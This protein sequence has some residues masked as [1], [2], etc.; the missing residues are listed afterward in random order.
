VNAQDYHDRILLLALFDAREQLDNNFPFLAHDPEPTILRAA[1]ERIRDRMIRETRDSAETLAN[2]LAVEAELASTGRDAAKV[3][4]EVDLERAIANVSARIAREEGRESDAEV[5]EASERLVT[6]PS[7]ELARPRPRISGTRPGRRHGLTRWLAA[8]AGGRDDVLAAVP[9]AQFRI[10]A[11]GSILFS[12]AILAGVSAVIAIRMCASISLWSAIVIGTMWSA[13]IYIIERSIILTIDRRASRLRAIVSAIPRI[14]LIAIVAI[15]IATPL[16]LAVFNREIATQV[17][18]D[19]QSTQRSYQAELT[20]QL[21]SLRNQ[22]RT[23][24]LAAAGLAPGAVSGDPSVRAATAEA[25][26][27]QLQYDKATDTYLRLSAQA[28][29]EFD[30][31]CGTH[32]PGDGAQYRDLKNQADVSRAA[33]AQA[34]AAL[35]NARAQLSIVTSRASAVHASLAKQDL[36][37][38]QGALA[39]AERQLASTTAAFNRSN[40]ENVGILARLDALN[41][42]ASRE[43]VVR[44]AWVLFQVFLVLLGILPVLTK[45]LMTLGPETAYDRV[46]ADIEAARAREAEARLKA[47]IIAAEIEAVLNVEEQGVAALRR[48]EAIRPFDAEVA[49]GQAATIRA[50]MVGWRESYKNPRS[51]R[52]S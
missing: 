31:T 6:P 39:G 36:A 37:Q 34:A 7:D 46:A 16:T 41:S 18:A 40:N 11:L 26:A 52:G 3:P 33:M 27:A 30:G 47:A 29:C 14:T 43:P 45:L 22:V 38:T 13:M 32:V 2:M 17:L 25:H 19:Q 5:A 9:S 28:Q 44:Q 50:S 1:I 23:D 42:L 51:G 49:D 35:N 24:Q 15:V 4:G 8:S 21:D 48:V 12:T 20:Q 10:A